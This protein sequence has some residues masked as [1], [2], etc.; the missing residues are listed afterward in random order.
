MTSKQSRDES[1]S[2]ENRRISGCSIED[3]FFQMM[4][5]IPD[6]HNEQ[7]SENGYEFG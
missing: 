3:K 2:E 4:N 6:Q 1:N 5:I 7:E